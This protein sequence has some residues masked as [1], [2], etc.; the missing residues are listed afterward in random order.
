MRPSSSL[1]LFELTTFGLI[2]VAIGVVISGVFGANRLWRR[3]GWKK[4]AGELDL[5][6]DESHH[7][8]EGERYDVPLVVRVEEMASG[9]GTKTVTQYEVPLGG[10][11]IPP[12]RLQ[13][14]Q[15]VMGVQ[16]D[17][18]LKRTEMEVG[19]KV[20][21]DAFIITG[22]DEEAIAEFFKRSG[23][24][25]ALLRCVKNVRGRLTYGKGRLRIT[26]DGIAGDKKLRHNIDELTRCGSA[27][28]KAGEAQL[29]D[30]SYSSDAEGPS[31]DQ[32]EGDDEPEKFG[33]W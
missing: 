30:F 5:F 23:V 7:L 2:I 16:L 27:L 20:L 22:D 10:R 15:R 19:L 14:E 33:A 25:S 8:L 21:D 9:T 32:D 13:P 28:A 18:L 12:M 3:R 6:C 11:G 17:A 1:T 4:V 29:A 31:E 26:H 24:A